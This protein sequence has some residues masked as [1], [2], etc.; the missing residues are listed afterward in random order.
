M[1]DPSPLIHLDYILLL[2]DDK[3]INIEFKQNSWEL[4]QKVHS[5]L[6]H[7]Q[8]I[9]RQQVF[10]F[11]LD[12]KINKNLRRAD[13]N[14]PTIVSIEGMLKVL[15]LYYVGLLPFIEIDDAVFGITLEEVFFVKFVNWMPSCDNLISF[16]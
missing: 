4:V 9:K 5:Y 15:V 10:W 7:N 14:I 8:Y 6:V 3:M 12:E 2:P 1:R 16:F 13:P 11:S